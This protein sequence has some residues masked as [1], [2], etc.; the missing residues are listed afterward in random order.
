MCRLEEVLH[1][2]VILLQKVLHVLDEILGLLTCL[3]VLVADAGDL[4]VEIL[5]DLGQVNMEASFI[6]HNVD[7]EVTFVRLSIE[8]SV[9]ET[10]IDVDDPRLDFFSGLEHL[11]TEHLQS[12]HSFPGAL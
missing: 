10:L 5:L 8:C 12:L 6:L 2:L 9:T 4:R 3:V 7:L 1:D 11:I